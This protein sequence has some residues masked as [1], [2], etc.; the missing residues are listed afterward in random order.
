VREHRAAFC[1]ALENGRWPRAVAAY[2]WRG[3]Y[4][5]M[6]AALDYCRRWPTLWAGP[7]LAPLATRGRLDIGVW[8]AAEV[9]ALH[10]RG[11]SFAAIAAHLRRRWE[12]C[13]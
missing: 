3:R 5:A 6:G 13:P 9:E 2:H 1:A 11:A 10:A 12:D 4:C 7:L 8:L